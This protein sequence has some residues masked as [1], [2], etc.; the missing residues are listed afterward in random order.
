[1]CTFTFTYERWCELKTD[2]NR[3][4]IS[5][6]EKSVRHYRLVQHEGMKFYRNLYFQLNSYKEKSISFSLPKHSFLLAWRHKS[7]NFHIFCFNDVELLSFNG[8]VF[9]SVFVCLCVYLSEPSWSSL[10]ATCTFIH[11]LLPCLNTNAQIMK[12][13]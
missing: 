4:D 10:L 6:F 5:Y 8:D 9:L 2:A 12:V 7:P 11:I 13:T 1:M 3:I